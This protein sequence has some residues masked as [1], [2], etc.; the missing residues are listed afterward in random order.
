T[1]RPRGRHRHPPLAQRAH[2]VDGVETEPRLGEHSE[3]PA[4]PG[5]DHDRFQVQADAAVRRA[6]VRPIAEVL[7][8][9]EETAEGDAG[10]REPAGFALDV[11]AADAERVEVAARE[12]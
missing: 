5:G 6:A 1:P 9:E 7:A 11:D 3:S 8:V 2:E 10:V 4:E 12:C